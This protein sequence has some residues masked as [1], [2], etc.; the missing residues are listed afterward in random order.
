[1][2]TFTDTV[3]LITGGT[4]GIGLATAVAFAREGARVVVAGRRETEGAEAV[5]AIEAAGGEGRFVQTDV[6]VERDVAA[7]VARTL[8]AF[9]RLDVA[10]NNAG[11]FLES[12]PVTEVSAETIDQILR[13]NVRGVALCLKHEIPALVASGGGAIVNTA[14][15]LGLRPSDTSAV[16]NASKA[17][18]IG[19]TK[20]VALEVAT[21][22]IRVNAVCPGVVATPMN[23]SYRQSDEGRAFLD[24]LQPVGRIGHPE[25]IAAA[26]L[27]LCSPGASFTT[28]TTLVV[29]GGI[30][31]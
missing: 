6:S 15:Y 3:A 26:V 28:G 17:A 14:S 18:V 11:V 25:E 30:A 12:G 9:G 23:E 13:V 7:M 29:D 20:S 27:Y 8:D 24:G 5:A 1:M 22:G 16:Y 19:L 10:V 21:Q 4:S 31:L 2:N